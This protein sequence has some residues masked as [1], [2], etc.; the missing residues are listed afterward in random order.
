[1][2][3]RMV[4]LLINLFSF[5]A[6]ADPIDTGMDAGIRG[7]HDSPAPPTD[8]TGIYKSIYGPWTGSLTQLERTML[9]DKNYIFWINVPPQHPMDM[10]S[11]EYF[12]RW[13][14]AVPKSELSI[15]HNMVAWRCKDA[16]G[17]TVMGATGMTGQNDKQELKMFLKGY[18][19]TVFLSTFTDG[20]LNSINEVNAYIN[21]N[22][23][24]RG[25]I[26]AGYEVT[27]EECSA[28]QDFL[29][30]FVD[31]PSKPY[32]NFGLLPDP[33]KME[34]GGCVTFASALLQHAG[35]LHSV[36]PQFYRK[37]FATHYL[38][39]GNLK[40]VVNTKIPSLDWLHGK[41]Y[42]VRMSKLYHNRWDQENSVVPGFAEMNIMDPEKMTYSLK[43]F[44]TIYLSQLPPTLRLQ[45]EAIFASSPLGLRIV[46]SKNNIGTSNGAKVQISYYPIDST[47]D[48]QM[49]QI[50]EV[51]RSWY[52]Q[53]LDEGFHIRRS[54]AMGMPVLL[55]ERK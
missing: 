48:P 8:P 10:R 19:L 43:Q 35:L 18:G 40:P 15:S 54:V 25:A 12:R 42:R 33:E 47:F 11:S 21:K 32:M 24:K 16:S 20:H 26:F 30:K 45:E 55:L 22:L 2:T 3:L 52:K 39:G 23:K 14:M 49:N 27:Q 13:M 37:I 44:A 41:K 46:K 51:A 50:A 5:T 29:H 38:M 31:H 53:K 7:G 17:K 34:G 28:M 36:V 6:F 9:P 1:M 4:F